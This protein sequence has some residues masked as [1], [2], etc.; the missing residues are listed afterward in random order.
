MTLLTYLLTYF[1]TVVRHR[2]LAARWRSVSVGGVRDLSTVLSHAGDVTTSG[3]V[4]CLR[5]VTVGGREL[6]VPGDVR[7]VM[8]SAN[9]TRD[10]CA[11]RPA[12]G[13]CA[14]RPCAN[15]GLCVDEWTSY[16]CQCPAGFTGPSCTTGLFHSNDTIVFS[17]VVGLRSRAS[18]LYSLYCL[19]AV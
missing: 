16:R 7:G 2:L 19:V 5:D 12:A 6:L 15:G 4:G 11:L 18:V 8:R 17:Y 10:S 1:L 3:F 13:Q 14:D 9:L